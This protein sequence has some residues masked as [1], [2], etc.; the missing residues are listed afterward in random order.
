MPGN[1]WQ[2]LTNTKKRK[3][4]PKL[5]SNRVECYATEIR[6]WYWCR[7]CVQVAGTLR[8]C[9]EKCQNVKIMAFNLQKNQNSILLHGAEEVLIAE[10]V[11]IEKLFWNCRVCAI[12]IE[13]SYNWEKRNRKYR[14]YTNESGIRQ[15]G[16]QELQNV[17]TLN[18]TLQH[19]T[20]VQT[21]WE[22]PVCSKVS[23]QYCAI[24]ERS[25][26]H[27]TYHSLL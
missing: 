15:Q 14:H 17:A 5:F 25:N 18:R 24:K 12:M 8:Y 9:K 2:T 1:F 27:F 22:V 19:S 10:W 13:V 21:Y 7:Q 11:K 26:S 4:K 23:A 3:R 16:K 20:I 6:F